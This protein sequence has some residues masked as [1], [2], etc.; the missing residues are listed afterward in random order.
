MIDISLRRAF[1]EIFNNMGVNFD[2]EGEVKDL[3]AFFDAN[4]ML[5]ILSKGENLLSNLTATQ[6]TIQRNIDDEIVDIDKVQFSDYRVCVLRFNIYIKSA[7]YDLVD[8]V[9]GYDK[10]TNIMYQL[11]APYA[12]EIYSKYDIVFA[13]KPISQQWVP[14][15]EGVTFVSRLI[16]SYNVSYNVKQNIELS[17]DS[18]TFKEL[19]TPEA[20]SV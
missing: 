12:K 8:G 7:I 14:S 2:L 16:L 9:S 11:Q 18:E 19:T 17:T 13:S 5:V 20:H 15:V 3:E 4:D 10:M 1:I 6:E